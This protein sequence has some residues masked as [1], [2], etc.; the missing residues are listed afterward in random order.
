MKKHTDTKRPRLATVLAAIALCIALGGT[1]TAASGL[2]HG[3]KIKPGTIT[4]KQIRNKTLSKAK[5]TPATI[6][7]LRGPQGPKGEKG[8]TGPKGDPGVPGP[9]VVTSY[10]VDNSVNNVNS[11]T[12]VAAFNNMKSSR[13][14]IIAKAIMF[15]NTGGTMS[16]CSIE[17]SGGEGDE[18]QWTSPGNFTRTTVPIVLATQKKVTQIKFTCDPGDGTGAFTVDA[19]AIPIG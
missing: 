5:F 11:K 6:A 7:A 17:A 2:I 19:I 15:A 4:A 12:Q 1:A 9:E 3:K 18:A 14:L 16:R 8:Q 13:Y 10:S